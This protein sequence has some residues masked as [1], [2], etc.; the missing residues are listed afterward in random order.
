MRFRHR[1]A[2]LIAFVLAAASGVA[3]ADLVFNG[4]FK[5]WEGG[6]PAGWSVVESPQKVSQDM[7]ADKPGALKVEVV[8]ENGK[9]LGEITQTI[10]VQP[11]QKYRFSGELKSTQAGKALF[12]LKPK[13]KKELA[14]IV[15]DPA[16]E[17]WTKVTKEFDTGEAV[18][19]QVLCR[20]SQKTDAVGMNA[21]FTNVSLVR[22]DSAGNPIEE[23]A[24]VPAKAA[25]KAKPKV[26]KGAEV[27]AAPVI[28]AAGTDQYVSA[29]GKGNKSGKDWDN[30]RAGDAASVQAAIDAAGPGNTVHI[31]SGTYDGLALTVSG[32]GS[33]DSAVKTIAG[34]DTGGGLPIIKTNWTKE[35]SEKS[36]KTAFSVKPGV[37]FLTIRDI[38]MLAVRGGVKLEGGNTRITLAN[39]DIQECRDAIWIEGGATPGN[40]QSGSHDIVVR[41]SKFTHYTKRGMRILNGVW[42][43]QV[44][45][46]HADAGGKEWF[47]E[48]FPVGF[49]V[50]GGEGVVDHDITFTDCTS[51]NNYHDAGTKYWNAD[52]WASESAT[53]NLTFIRCGAFDNTDGGWDLK[54]PANKFVDCISVGNKR[55]YRIWTK[56]G[57]GK[58][59]FENCLSAFSRD[60]GPN[61]HD[62]GFWFLVGGE[63]TMKNVTAWGDRKAIRVE[64]N[65]K[66]PPKMHLT[67]DHCLIVTQEGGTTQD[68]AP[69][70]TVENTGSIITNKPA[71]APQLKNPS[72][73]WRGG[74]NGFDSP[75]DF[76]FEY[77]SL[78]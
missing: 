39:L 75:G 40:D 27:P 8:A 33:G 44:I 67:L 11:N 69:E 29:E 42:N 62:V 20:F 71:E 61:G 53:R 48:P 13:N 78:K 2:L 72:V 63:V 68:L 6:K 49:H 18:E 38:K 9:N 5:Q 66:Y 74:D 76:G 50:I 58:T 35:N 73:N 64:A 14:R 10:K 51:S 46:C 47:A 3:R 30:A 77:H 34:A 25:A 36:G 17:E 52:G 26:Q 43:L 54:S 56:P 60:R 59:T 45:N 55:N 19:V 41:D 21:W 37:S 28:A 23:Q 15:V 32:G 4:D 7:P 12:M 1:S 70:A 16:T 22:L 31:G 24:A 65:E 57:E